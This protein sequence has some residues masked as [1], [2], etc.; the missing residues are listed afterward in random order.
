MEAADGTIDLEATLSI[1]GKSP[2]VIARLRKQFK[3]ARFAEV[4]HMLEQGKFEGDTGDALHDFFLDEIPNEAVVRWEGAIP[5]AEFDFP[6]GVYEYFGIFYVWALEYDKVGYFETEADAK[7][8]IYGNWDVVKDGGD[9]GVSDTA[10]A[11]DAEDLLAV[12][13]LRK[14]E[15]IRKKSVWYVTGSPQIVIGRSKPLQSMESELIPHRTYWDKSDAELL[16]AAK[17]GS[18]FL[19]QSLPVRVTKE[20]DHFTLRFFARP[21]G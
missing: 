12:V 21:L 1:L 15:G 14:V 6:V 2:K 16:F 17:S 11:D 9:V 13:N 3:G 8:Y 5:G 10:D 18:A 20:H 7:A 19:D 4:A